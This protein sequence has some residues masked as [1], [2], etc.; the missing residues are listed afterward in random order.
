MTTKSKSTWKPHTKHGNLTDRSDLPDSMYAF[1][2]QCKE[3]LTDAKLDQNALTR[4][5]QATGVSDTERTQAFSNIL[6][7]AK[8]YHVKV[9][10]SL[11]QLLLAQVEVYP[12][13]LVLFQRQNGEPL[14]PISGIYP[15]SL[16]PNVQEALASEQYAIRKLLPQV[17][18]HWVTLPEEQHA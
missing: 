1:P 10:V 14:D 17:P 4:F 8:Y 13:R 15:A 9:N 12:D 7:D 11:L 2:K 18:T 16:L 5:D 6:E 3:A